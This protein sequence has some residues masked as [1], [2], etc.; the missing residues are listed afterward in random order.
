MFDGT[1]DSYGREAPVLHPASVKNG[2]LVRVLCHLVLEAM[3]GEPPRYKLH[4]ESVIVAAV[5]PDPVP[6]R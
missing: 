3:V 2:D 5:C 1:N 4:V 6:V